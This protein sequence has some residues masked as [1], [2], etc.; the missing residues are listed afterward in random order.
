MAAASLGAAPG[1]RAV[2]GGHEDRGPLARTSV[3][4][5]NAR[6]GVCSGVVVGPAAILTAAHCVAGSQVRIH[7]RQADG[8]PALIEP[9][10][11]AIHPGYDRGA[12]AGRRRSIDLALVRSTVPLPSAFEPASLTTATPHTGE[13]LTLAGYGIAREGDGRSSGTFR[14]AS[15]TLAEPYGPST[16]LVWAADPARSGA[17]ACEGDSGGPIA[18]GSGEVLAVTTWASGAGRRHCGEMS[19]GILIGPQRAWIDRTL[20]GWG[21]AAAAWR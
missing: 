18:L 3:M 1:A 5:L 11:V 14:A 9:A 2:V 6:G 12:I 10:S 16:I 15:L 8:S 7:F 20:A 19:Q 17:G 4:V 13:P 21:V